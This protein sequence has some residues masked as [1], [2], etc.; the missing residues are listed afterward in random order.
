MADLATL[1]A[2]L[3]ELKAARASGV[4]KVR[5]RD[6][7][8]W[9]KTDTEMASAIRD[10]EAEIAAAD[11]LPRIKFHTITKDRGWS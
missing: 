4:S 1:R 9:F 10:L 11:G 3:D 2:Q 7:E 6:R 8:T 5:F